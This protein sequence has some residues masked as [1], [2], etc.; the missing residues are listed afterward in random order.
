MN[1]VVR[2]L[3]VEIKMEQIMKGFMVELEI[4]RKNG[5]LGGQALDICLKLLAQTTLTSLRTVMNSSSTSSNNERPLPSCL[6]MRS[7]G[8]AL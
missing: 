4:G 5:S 3:E 6:P 2:M 1:K 7:R 8:L